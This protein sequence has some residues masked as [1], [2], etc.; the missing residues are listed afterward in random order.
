MPNQNPGATPSP[1]EV[2]VSPKSKKTGKKGIIVAISLVVFLF[3]AVLIG[4]QLVRQN[5]NLE[6]KADQANC[7]AG[8]ACPHPEQPN[9]LSDCSG[10]A[11]DP[12]DSL[13]NAKGRVESCGGASYCCPGPNQAWT[14]NMAACPSPSP[15]ASAT[16]S[17]SPT[18]TATAS[19]TGSPSASGSAT[20]TPTG[21][22]TA[23]PTVRPTSTSSSTPPPVPATGTEWPTYLGLGVGVLVIIG[24]FLLAL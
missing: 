6:E 22:R 13:C 24:S 17:A 8:E 16:A 7:P 3:A 15:T 21:T 12:E 2:V 18:A 10:N 14:R 5:Q 19:P 1:F 20:P 23:T 11:V 4:V 9:L